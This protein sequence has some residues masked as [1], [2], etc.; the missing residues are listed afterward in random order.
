M[1]GAGNAKIGSIVEGTAADG[2][3][4]RNKFL[5]AIPALKKLVDAVAIKAKAGFV[6]GLDGRK[7][8]VRSEHAALNSLL[9]SAGA[10]V[11]KYALVI[12][13]RKITEAN[14]DA[15]FVLNVHDEFQLEVHKDHA[16]QLGKLAE[17]SLVEAGV[18]LGIRIPITG[19][20]AIGKTWKETH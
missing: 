8:Y 14:L 5:K 4:L 15:K 2:A 20:Y 1:Y 7:I 10:I 11:M 18:E 12:L 13:D 3:K 17:E 16:E 6:R 19:T 9:Q